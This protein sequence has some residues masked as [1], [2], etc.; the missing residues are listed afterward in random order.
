MSML[1]MED[2][3]KIKINS[4]NIGRYT[5]FG[6]NRKIGDTIW[7]CC[8]ETSSYAREKIEVPCSDCGA[9]R[10]ISAG[11]YIAH[12][13]IAY[14][15]KCSQIH[16]E[17]TT[18]KKYGCKNVFQLKEVQEKQKETIRRVY[19]TDNVFQNEEIKKKSRRTLIEKYG[20]DHPMHIPEI[21]EIV[22][23][24]SF[25]T[26]YKNGKQSCSSQQ[27]HIHEIVGG[28]L[29]YLIDCLWL[30]IYFDEDK[31]YLEYDGSGHD[32]DVKYHKCTP[33]EFKQKETIR[34]EVLK[35]KGLKEIQIISMDDVLPEDEIIANMKDVSF[36]VLKSGISNY[37]VFDID[38]KILRYKNFEMQYNFDKKLYFDKDNNTIVTTVGEGIF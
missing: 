26:L 16:R 38:K 21:K 27:R 24:K 2:K 36:S 6:Y 8:Y 30:D 3:M 28:E 17:E 12:N 20:A 13:K 31:I 5:R 33:E 29:N 14:C 37:I 22:K 35:S 19:G 10:I 4:G 25:E 15:K 32:I 23:Q 1:S 18:M 7:V 34:Y 11:N 9:L